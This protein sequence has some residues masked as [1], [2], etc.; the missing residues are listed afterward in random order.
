[1]TKEEFKK[2][3]EGAIALAGE[4]ITNMDIEVPYFR[5]VTKK[6]PDGGQVD[7]Y[8]DFKFE[9]IVVEYRRMNEQQARKCSIEEVP[10]ILSTLLEVLDCDT[11]TYIWL[12]E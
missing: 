12:G 9:M 3:I 11:A 7:Y 4:V 6:Y 8:Y 1:M 10:D 2:K 5:I